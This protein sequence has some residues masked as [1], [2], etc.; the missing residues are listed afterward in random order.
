MPE[1]QYNNT[2]KRFGPHSFWI[3]AVLIVLGT[4]G[5]VLPTLM[6]VATVVLV[7]AFMLAAGTLWLWHSI[8]HGTGWSDWLKPILLLFVGGLI[9]YQPGTGI[10]SVAL[11]IMVYLAL[12]AIAS[13]SLARGGQGRL[14]QGW[15]VVSGLV[16]ILLVT[17]FLW[18]WPQSSLWMVGLFVGISLIVDGW[19]LV[20]IGW[21]LRRSGA[22][23]G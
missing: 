9:A 23:R 22:V 14:G 10:A 4:F 11:L 19:A 16:D 21:S 2:A 3:G 7:A 18:G 6:S 12:D 20:M 17:V 1:H 8:K 15:M 13:F 5:V